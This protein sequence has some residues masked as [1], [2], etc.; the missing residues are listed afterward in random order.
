PPPWLSRQLFLETVDLQATKERI[1]Y[2]KTFQGK[3]FNF[4]G[5]FFSIYFLWKIFMVRVTDIV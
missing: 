3:Y 4:L 1:E 5:Y 2:S